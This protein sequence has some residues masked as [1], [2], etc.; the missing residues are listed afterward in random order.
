ME[1]A[2]LKSSLVNWLGAEIEC[3]EED[4]GVLAS[5]CI[6]QPNGDAIEIGIQPLEGNT[7]R[8]SD[9]GIAHET[10]YLVG[11]DLSDEES[12]RTDEFQQIIKD[13]GLTY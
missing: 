9:L 3:H 7:W 4:N 10:L 2:E 5:F 6:Y 13:F 11:I 12:D 1:C 8:I